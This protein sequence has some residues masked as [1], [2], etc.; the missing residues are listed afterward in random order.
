MNLKIR[1]GKKAGQYEHEYPDRCVKL[2]FYD[3][4]IISGIPEARECHDFNWVQPNE[5]K[6]ENF[7]PADV[8]IIQIL[9][10]KEGMK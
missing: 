5:M 4:E 7:P 8:S 2:Y 3:C 10:V 6:L 9:Q 1:V